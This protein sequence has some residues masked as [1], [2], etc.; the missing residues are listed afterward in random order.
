MI[1]R[2]FAICC[3]KALQNGQKITYI[4]I[5]RAHLKKENAYT[6]TH[7]HTR[8]RTRIT[9]EIRAKGVGKVRRVSLDHS[10]CQTL[11]LGGVRCK[12]AVAVSLM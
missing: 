4:Q 11:T 7:S 1:D 6:H 9:C 12:D 5:K 8:S 2:I 10:L 3:R